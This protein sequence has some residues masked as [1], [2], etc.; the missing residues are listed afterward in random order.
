[1]VHL[2]D[3]I[4]IYTTLAFCKHNASIYYIQS[5]LLY[6]QQ[7]QSIVTDSY[8]THAGNKLKKEINIF[9]FINLIYL[10]HCNGTEASI[11]EH[12]GT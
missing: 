5:S 2:I 7:D 1:M 10:T 4:S 12:R 8:D 11:R 3:L 9:L 6:P